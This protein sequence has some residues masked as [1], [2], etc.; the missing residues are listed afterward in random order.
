MNAEEQR[1]AFAHRVGFYSKVFLILG[2]GA[3]LFEYVRTILLI[4]EAP[5]VKILIAYP[6]SSII[7]RK[8][9]P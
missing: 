5:P 4:A 8:H 3:V 7:F 1:V 6:I 2:V 9:L